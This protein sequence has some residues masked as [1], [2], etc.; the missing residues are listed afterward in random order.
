[1]QGVWK[2]WVGIAV[3]ILV[4][5]AAIFYGV[6]RCMSTGRNNSSGLVSEKAPPG[7][8]ASAVTLGNYAPY[9]SPQ[10]VKLVV[11]RVKLY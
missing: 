1:M 3:G 5:L 6:N 10:V 9:A 4:T 2:M 7:D 11:K 8:V